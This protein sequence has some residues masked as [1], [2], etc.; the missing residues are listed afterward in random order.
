MDLQEERIAIVGATG[1]L[2]R[3][4][5]AEGARRGL[6]IVA[7]GHGPDPASG[8]EALDVGDMAS[9]ERALDVAPSVVLNTA[10]V[11]GAQFY[12]AADQDAFFRVN[13][14]GAWNLARW[15]AMHGARLVHFSTD[16]V[17]GGD[18]RR[19]LPYAETDAPAP[20]N[21]YGA[22]KLAGE[23]LIAASCAAHYVVR[24][25]SLYG[26]G[27]CRAK[28]NSNFVELVLQKAGQN[29][30]MTMVADQVMSP[31]ATRDVALRTFDLLAAEAPFGVYHM[32]G[33]GHCSWYDFA[34]EIARQAGLDAE[35]A[36][37]STPDE[38]DGAAFV[39]PRYTALDNAALRH[40]GLPDLPDWRDALS[41][42]LAARVAT[43]AA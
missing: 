37:T 15:C 42:Y 24:V 29:E 1:Q 26:I 18:R 7:L 25:A 9:I 41:H 12:T 43:T 3:D 22:S 17:F 36:A 16:Y 13:A 8:A 10:A 40:A 5:C 38:D 19:G 27:G 34:R 28:K 21:I 2:G 4:L 14:I 30:P 31:T 6:E 39:R 33:R 11:H 32:A 20:V 23:Q 35:I